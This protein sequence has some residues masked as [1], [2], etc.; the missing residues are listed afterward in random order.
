MSRRL[1]DTARLVRTLRNLRPEQGVHRARL[2]AQ[3][4]TLAR[5][6]EFFEQRWA[7]AV[8][9]SAGWP[10]EFVPVDA[11]APPVV[12]SIDDL[13]KR[14]FG[15]VGEQHCIDDEGGWSPQATTQLFRYHLHYT[16]WACLL[17]ED[18]DRGRA[19]F[20]ELW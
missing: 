14:E 16:E 7:R 10:H 15:L 3:K 2:R 8:P 1:D 4:F 17:A 13:A 11:I 19:V 20:D 5:R 9:S 18:P 6:P 12:G